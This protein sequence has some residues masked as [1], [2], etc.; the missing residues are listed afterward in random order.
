[1]ASKYVLERR[2][3]DEFTFTFKT[4]DGKVLLTSDAYKDKDSALHAISAA[5]QLAH[6]KKNYELLTTEIGL[7]YFVLKNARGQVIGHSKTF[8][9]AHSLRQEILL[10]KAITRG[11]RLEDHTDME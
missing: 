5:R 8:S 1:M 9:D 2:G 7:V 3:D 10:A 6:H 4:H 11:S